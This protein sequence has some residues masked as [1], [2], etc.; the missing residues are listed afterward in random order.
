MGRTDGTSWT[1]GVF[2]DDGAALDSRCRKEYRERI[3]KVLEHIG[4]HLDGDLSLATLSGVAGFSPYHFHRIFHSLVGETIQTH[5]KRQRLASAAHKV[6]YRPDLT[7]TA[8]ALDCGFSNPADF[9]R[10]FTVEFGMSAS[11]Y[12]RQKRNKARESGSSSHELQRPVMPAVSWQDPGQVEIRRMEDCRI[13]YI[14][15]M[16][17][18]ADRNNPAIGKAFGQLLRWGREHGYVDA[19]T[20]LLGVTLDNPEVTPMPLCRYDACITVPLRA[21]AEGEIGVRILPSSGEYAVRSFPKLGPAFEQTFFSQVLAIY[22]SWLPGHGY[23][24]DDK[25]FL[26]VFHMENAGTENISMDF[27]IPILPMDAYSRKA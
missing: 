26:E 17:L 13:A 21:D 14:R 19:S 24:P 27:C 4:T 6:L 20:R 8:I 9:A 15:C 1:G 3:N 11:R 10:S 5:V 25:P 18:S 22:G 12:S 7:I 23:V 2:V 16:G